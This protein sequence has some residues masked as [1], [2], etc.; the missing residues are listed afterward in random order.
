M[1]EKGKISQPININSLTSL[2]GDVKPHPNSAFDHTD[3]RFALN[4]DSVHDFLHFF[5]SCDASVTIHG[6]MDESICLVIV[7][8]LSRNQSAF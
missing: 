6:N 5:G 3:S 4:K 1:E 8:Q 2:D 7:L